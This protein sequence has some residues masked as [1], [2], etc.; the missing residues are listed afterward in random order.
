MQS[1][2]Y[3]LMTEEYAASIAEWTYEE[4]YSFYN[5]DDSEETISEL[6]NGEY[7]YVLNSD[8][9]LFGF[10]CIGESARVS[11]GYEIGIYNDDKC[12]DLGLG[13]APSRTGMGNGANFL[14][15]SIKFII[16]EY[17]TSNIQLVVAAFN[18][19]A[20]KV[21][22]RVG[23][24]KSQCFKSRVGEEKIDF[25]LMKLKANNEVPGIHKRI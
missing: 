6:M 14:D 25:V 21:Y 8:N 3:Y 18:E 1:F 24:V 23:F 19:R 17:Q 2:R 16:E 7:Y 11:G 15:A 12:L 9:E 10:I 5:M 22:E 20:I 4:S 13:L